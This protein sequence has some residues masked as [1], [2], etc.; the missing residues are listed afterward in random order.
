MENRVVIEEKMLQV[1]GYELQVM[2]FKFRHF[3]IYNK[4]KGLGEGNR[5]WRKKRVASFE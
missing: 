1:A 4:N 2:G 3:A 5:V